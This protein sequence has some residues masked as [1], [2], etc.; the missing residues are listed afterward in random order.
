M[1]TQGRANVANF[2]GPQAA[3][4]LGFVPQVEPQPAGEPQPTE[5]DLMAMGG[6]QPQG[7]PQAVGGGS[8]I[9]GID[10]GPLR[11]IEGRMGTASRER[12]AGIQGSAAA[13][14][15]AVDRAAT[16]QAMRL[17]NEAGIMA[18]NEAM[19]A[20]HE[21]IQINRR[22]EAE[23]VVTG[24]LADFDKSV[25]EANAQSIDPDRWY[26]DSSG[27]TFGRRLGASIA[28]ALGAFG[29]AFTKGPNYAMQIIQSAIDRDLMSQRAEM[30]KKQGAVGQA[31]NAVGM[32][33]AS[34]QDVEARGHAERAA[35][36]ARAG[37]MID[38]SRAQ[39]GSRESMANAE[40]LKAQIAAEAQ[41]ELG[42]AKEKE[43]AGEYGRATAMAGL[44]AKQQQAAIDARQASQARAAGVPRGLTL[45]DPN[46][47]PSAKELAE[48][49]KKNA[50]Y[51]RAMSALVNLRQIRAKEGAELKTPRA[52]KVALKQATKALAERM[53]I[54]G[55]Q[56]L[57]AIKDPTQ[58]SLPSDLGEV[59]SV[60]SQ[61]DAQI[62]NLRR[63]HAADMQSAGGGGL[64]LEDT[65]SMAASKPG[66]EKVR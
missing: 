27:G 41:K 32:A 39:S 31:Q 25:Q 23:K 4:A 45:A 65:Q 30:A 35:E 8:A 2:L 63:D 11:D 50:L 12:L 46:N 55:R 26:R 44:Q 54:Q 62:E 36:L 21:R 10:L 20:V 58:V 38:I 7:A 29:A 6:V 1:E 64:M 18:E 24:R 17:K 5:A 34:F 42:Q 66:W 52:S 43:L 61:V 22:V 57:N 9:P 56:M 28:L 3:A 15:Q 14:T 51:Q 49:Q 37:R 60:L 53:G 13:R 33:R 47:P 40:S 48:A 19:A 16:E 59:G